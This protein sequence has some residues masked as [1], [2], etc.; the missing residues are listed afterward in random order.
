MINVSKNIIY[1]FIKTEYVFEIDW[2]EYN[3]IENKYRDDNSIHPD[4]SYEWTWLDI[5]WKDESI[6][7]ILDTI[8]NL[9]IN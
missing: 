9:L 7:D 2:I 6:W 5:D 1:E 8:N 3:I 4:Y